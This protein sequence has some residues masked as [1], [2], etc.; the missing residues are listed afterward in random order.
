[1]NINSDTYQI[2]PYHAQSLVSSHPVTLSLFDSKLI[3]QLPAPAAAALL[4]RAGAVFRTLML[5][6]TT[7]GRL[8]YSDPISFAM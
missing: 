4:A 6:P 5:S 7:G 2:D 3:K 8:Y 1:M